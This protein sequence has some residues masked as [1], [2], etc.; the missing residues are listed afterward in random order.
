MLGAHLPGLLL[1]LLAW[2]CRLLEADVCAFGLPWLLLP[3]CFHAALQ[4]IPEGERNKDHDGHCVLHQLNRLSWLHLVRSQ[5]LLWLGSP[6]C[7]D[8][9]IN[10]HRPSLGCLLA[11]ARHG[12]FCEDD[13]FE[14]RVIHVRHADRSDEPEQWLY[15]KDAWQWNQL[16]R[17]GAWGKLGGLVDIVRDTSYVLSTTPCLCLASPL[18]RHR[19]KHPK[20]DW[21]YRDTG[22]SKWETARVEKCWLLIQNIRDHRERCEDDGSS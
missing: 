5:D 16:L 21:V 6:Y 18:E 12:T 15:I 22:I 19:R 7:N 1:L 4:H 20:G 17:G 9:D 8:H 11:P 3:D 13:P 14:H 2:S 10:S